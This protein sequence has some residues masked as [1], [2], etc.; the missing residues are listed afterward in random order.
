[1]K[2]FISMMGFALL[3]LSV[4]CVERDVLERDNPNDS[5]SVLDHDGDD[6]PD[7][8][9]ADPEDATEW[10]DTDDVPD[11]TDN[12]LGLDNADQNDLDSD[13]EGDACDDDQDGDGVGNEEDN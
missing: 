13:G 12:C 11:A 9:D 3:S 5:Q 8:E 4:A 1:M 10:T 2:L 7:N 6:V